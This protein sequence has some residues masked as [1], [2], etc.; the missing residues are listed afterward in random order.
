M[1]GCLGC[2]RCSGSIDIGLANTCF[3]ARDE[4]LVW[5]RAVQSL[6]WCP[7]VSPFL[8]SG[9]MMFP[10]CSTSQRS[11]GATSRAASS[12]ALSMWHVSLLIAPRSCITAFSM[13]PFV[14]ANDRVLCC[15]FC[16]APFSDSVA[17]S[18]DGWLR[19]ALQCGI[20]SSNLHDSTTLSV[21][22]GSS[23]PFSESHSP[24]KIMSVFLHCNARH[25]YYCV[26][27]G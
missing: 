24:S 22:H 7:S 21:T 6:T 15:N 16:P 13:W 20:C 5:S 25:C 8:T 3:D 14:V 1:H 27:P 26:A 4:Y 18:D 12:V 19:V 9:D 10:A 17:E 23:T 11:S 2:S